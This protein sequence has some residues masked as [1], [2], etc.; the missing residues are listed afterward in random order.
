MLLTHLLVLVLHYTGK[1]ATYVFHMILK[2][3]VFH[4]F[5]N[6]CF[7]VGPKHMFTYVFKHMKNIC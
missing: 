3:Y 4:M 2:T 7:H 1:I 5:E 6:I